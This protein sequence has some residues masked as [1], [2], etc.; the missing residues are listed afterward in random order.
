M[1]LKHTLYRFHNPI[2]NR[3]LKSNYV[4]HTKLYRYVMRINKLYI[5]DSD[6]RVKTIFMTCKMKIRSK[7][8]I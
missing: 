2:K 5:H 4:H 7:L 8:W 1:D 3:F 6:V